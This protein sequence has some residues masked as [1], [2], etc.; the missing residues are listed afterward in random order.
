MNEQASEELK[1]KAK[2]EQEKARRDRR[3]LRGESRKGKRTQ[4]QTSPLTKAIRR[5]IEE[6]D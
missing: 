5:A 6:A 4:L 1:Q 2:R 3:F